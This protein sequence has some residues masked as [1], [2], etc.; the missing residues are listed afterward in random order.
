LDKEEEMMPRKRYSRYY[1]Y[2]FPMFS[3]FSYRGESGWRCVQQIGSA[4]PNKKKSA[5]KTAAEYRAKGHK[6]RIVYDSN[7]YLYVI[8]G[9][10]RKNW[11]KKLS[12]RR[13][14]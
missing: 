3:Y 7:N 10:K 4:V 8:V 9:P 1:Q 14:R 13:S 12:K 11:K 2:R 6:V 5:K